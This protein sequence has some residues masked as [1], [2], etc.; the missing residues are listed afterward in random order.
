[1]SYINPN[2][3]SVG[4]NE[5]QTDIG[6]H[7]KQILQ[8]SKSTINNNNS[9]NY[10][11]KPDH[12]SMTN[13]RFTFKN[14][15]M[16]V[17]QSIL[18]AGS[19]DSIPMLVTRCNACLM[20]LKDLIRQAYDLIIP[21]S[22]Y[23]SVILMKTPLSP[24]ITAQILESLKL[25]DHPLLKVAEDRCASCATRFIQLKIDA[26][27]YV[28][29]SVLSVTTG[30]LTRLSPTLMRLNADRMN[31]L[32]NENSYCQS[33]E[34]DNV[35]VDWIRTSQSNVQGVKPTR[36]HHIPVSDNS[37][38]QHIFRLE[39][40]LQNSPQ[41]YKALGFKLLNDHFRTENHTPHYSQGS[42]N[43]VNKLQEPLYQTT[44]SKSAGSTSTFTNPYTQG[45]HKLLNNLT[46]IPS[47]QH[48]IQRTYFPAVSNH[49]NTAIYHQIGIQRS[50][51]TNSNYIRVDTNH[52]LGESSLYAHLGNRETEFQ[53]LNPVCEAIKNKSQLSCP[54]YSRSIR[55]AAENGLISAAK[56][57]QILWES[58]RE[59]TSPL[60]LMQSHSEDHHQ[61]VNNRGETN[62]SIVNIHQRLDNE[63]NETNQDQNIEQDKIIHQLIQSNKG[64]KINQ[65]PS[66]TQISAAASFFTRAGQ[67][68]AVTNNSK[69]KR[70]ILPNDITDINH[71][72]GY[73]TSTLYRYNQQSKCLTGFSEAIHH[74]P[75]P[76]PPTLLKWS[77]NGTNNS[78][79]NIKTSKVKIILQL[80]SDH[81]IDKGSQQKLSYLTVEKRKNQVC[82]NDPNINGN[83]SSTN[84]KCTN[85]HGSKLFAMDGI[86]TEEDSMAE[87]CAF[88]LTDIIQ[89][90]V[91]GSDGCLIS[92]GTR[93]SI[94]SNSMFGDDKQSSGLGII[95]SA[96]SW[97]FRLITEQKER[98]GARFSVRISAVEVCGKEEALRD[99]LSSVS[100]TTDAAG[101]NAP[102]VYLREDPIS[103]T[104][105]ENQSELRA[106]T[107]DKAAFYLDS[108]LSASYQS[109]TT[110]SSSVKS[111]T[112]SSPLDTNS[113]SPTI[114]WKRNSHLFFT[115]HIY[116]Y[117]VERSGISTGVAG[118]RSRLHLIDL[119][120][121]KLPRDVETDNS[122][123]TESQ[124]SENKQTSASLN[125]SMLSLSSMTSV[126]LALINGNRHHPHRNSKLSQMLREAIGSIGCRTCILIQTSPNV[127]YYHENLQLLQFASKIQRSRRH[128]THERTLVGST[129]N[130]SEI[131]SKVDDQNTSSEDSSSCDSFGLRRAGRLRLNMGLRLAM[132]RSNGYKGFSTKYRHYG[133]DNPLSVP[134]S[135]EKDYTSSSEQSCDTVI[136]L[137]RQGL[138]GHQYDQDDNQKAR[139]RLGKPTSGASMDT[140]SEA[141]SGSK[142][143][144]FEGQQSHDS[145][146]GSS[147]GVRR[148][149]GGAESGSLGH[150]GSHTNSGDHCSPH[151]IHSKERKRSAPRTNVYA[152]PRNAVKNA[153]ETLSTQKE[154]WVDGP[155]SD[156]HPS[157]PSH[158]ASQTTTNAVVKPSM[159]DKETQVD[160]LN[161]TSAQVI[162]SPQLSS[163]EEQHPISANCTHTYQ[164]VPGKDHFEQKADELG[165]TEQ[166]KQVQ[167]IQKNVSV[168]P[169]ALERSNITSKSNKMSQMERITDHCPNNGEVQHADTTLS[170]QCSTC[171]MAGSLMNQSNLTVETGD[172]TNVIPIGN[173]IQLVKPQ[174]LESWTVNN[175]NNNNNN[176]ESNTQTNYTIHTSNLNQMTN[177]NPI[178][179]QSS[180]ECHL[181]KSFMN[182]SDTNAPIAKVKPFVKDWIQKHSTLPINTNM[183]EE[184]TKI[185]E[186]HQLQIMKSDENELCTV[187]NANLN[188]ALGE[189]G[190]EGQSIRHHIFHGKTEFMKPEDN[191]CSNISNSKIL[192]N[193]LF[194]NAAL[195]SK[196]PFINSLQTSSN[197]ARIAAWVKSVSVETYNTQES[198][199]NQSGESNVMI[200][201]RESL[202]NICTT[203]KHDLPA[204]HQTCYCRN[205]FE[206]ET[207]F[208]GERHFI[209][210]QMTRSRVCNYENA[211]IQSPQC[212][213]I[214]KLRRG[215]SVPPNSIQEGCHSEVPHSFDEYTKQDSVTTSER[216]T[217]P[218]PISASSGPLYGKEEKLN[219]CRKSDRDIPSSRR[220][221]GSSN[222]HLHKEPQGN[223]DTQNIVSCDNKTQYNSDIFNEKLSHQPTGFWASSKKSH[224][225][226][227]TKP[228]HE[229][230]VGF[231]PTTTNQY[232]N[233]HVKTSPLRKTCFSPETK[234]KSSKLHQENE[235]HL[236]VCTSPK[237][238]K[239]Q[240]THS[241]CSSTDSEHSFNKNDVFLDS[242]TIQKS[243][244]AQN[245]DS[246]GTKSNILQTPVGKKSS[247]ESRT[248]TS[249][250][251]LSF[252]TSPLFGKRK[253]KEVKSS[254]TAVVQEIKHVGHQTVKNFDLRR[255]PL[256]KDSDHSNQNKHS[257]SQVDTSESQT[258]IR[259]IRKDKSSSKHIQSEK[260]HNSSKNTLLS[261]AH[262]GNIPLTFNTP[263]AST[264]ISSMQSSSGHGSECSSSLLTEHN[265]AWNS[266]AE[267]NTSL[268]CRCKRHH[269]HTHQHH[270]HSGTGQRC[271]KCF[272]SSHACRP[273]HHNNRKCETVSETRRSADG[274]RSS[275]SGNS[276]SGYRKVENKETEE[277]D[278][279]C[280]DGKVLLETFETGKLSIG[281][282]SSNV[283][284]SGPRR[285][286]GHAS[287]GYE[288]IVRDSEASSHADSTSGSSAGGIGVVTA[289]VKKNKTIPQKH[290]TTQ[291][292]C[293]HCHRIN[294][295]NV[296]L[297]ERIK[298]PQV[299]QSI[300]TN[301]CCKEEQDKHEPSI[302]SNSYKIQY[303]LQTVQRLHSSKID[304]DVN[305]QELSC[306]GFQKVHLTSPSKQ[307]SQ[308]HSTNSKSSA[309]SKTVTS[310]SLSSSPSTSHRSRSAPPCSE[311]TS[312]ETTSSPISVR[313]VSNKPSENLLSQISTN[314][315]NSVRENSSN[316]SCILP[317]YAEEVQEMERQIRYEKT[318][319]LLAQQD[320]LKMELMTAKD[321]LLIDPSTWSFDLY[322][323][324][325]MDPD[326]PSFLEA[327]EKE[328]EILRKR[329][330][331]CKSHIMLITCFDSQFKSGQLSNV[332]NNTRT[333]QTINI[334][335]TNT[336]LN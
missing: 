225:R 92:F 44:L 283:S 168:K 139:S 171:V 126:V 298:E 107:A 145:P 304:S 116:Q 18:H 122:A 258:R 132:K 325:Q 29:R 41:N 75:P 288:S 166:D 34:A 274:K 237:S 332:I 243:D 219:I 35:K 244:Y 315:K 226:T 128:R 70:K 111:L 103:G 286:G 189:I 67:K 65:Q 175:N 27:S 8:N 117:R 7:E 60:Q 150:S 336:D 154:Q 187:I 213:K 26:L 31:L 174:S 262:A 295:T 25:P 253:E 56:Q 84:L 131:N 230:T 21:G 149:S 89:S 319:D 156:F 327:L 215:R 210:H 186:H 227:N 261:N 152:W 74:H 328:T 297:D 98:T 113:S 157:N 291:E 134:A 238:S 94:K 229:E 184:F 33:S 287:S 133:L 112:A 17:L 100:N 52:K 192:G 137:G 190:N 73:N 28:R 183:H 4:L 77:R 308:Q 61:S 260:Q 127:N 235:S 303:N 85:S 324:E 326:D 155:K 141:S 182:H 188:M 223:S 181:T 97:L 263:I 265:S 124:N 290:C 95:P 212:T 242:C 11:N 165:K 185:N 9:N 46:F 119:G 201:P 76:M 59:K 273:D 53:H 129:S 208:S 251:R 121:T 104:Q 221:D 241:I 293:E 62:P 42:N 161:Q 48:I 40:S 55:W 248:K 268:R 16:S 109:V 123:D 216:T 37:R 197:F 90:V 245:D 333:N 81:E 69:R 50:L 278:S 220:P 86:F 299:I 239:C 167:N 321:R 5:L 259:C 179:K 246:I 120:N 87:L 191:S 170:S 102:G 169:V 144:Q 314:V 240:R 96:I 64:S 300:N 250:G 302:Q 277:H 318:Y 147:V 270:H 93:D 294:Q 118:G 142:V 178:M 79:L 110:D 14:T 276:I 204:N 234:K 209:P 136:Y 228:Y 45:D 311:D 57:Q 206:N 19:M 47:G 323:A 236:L 205:N 224:F 316:V 30:K 177:V 58:S 39:S 71:L 305:N 247:K 10:L 63:I 66:V 83:E 72:S 101:A 310:Q 231:S 108:A 20:C 148:G 275:E 233:T 279:Q 1:M 38:P 269:H 217:A 193:A 54:D 194:G 80:R 135:S 264:K 68:L 282:P 203:A 284:G 159:I 335:Y 78:A 309:T 196:Q 160:E 195:Q 105:L 330:D 2:Y 202:T 255:K 301:S 32:P 51:Q 173:N 88:A 257:S 232:S 249:K 140:G 334:T 130:N 313:Y 125:D 146:V 200:K 6:F 143:K 115:L 15:T 280:N 254:E 12:I 222:P 256:T 198:G 82:L 207:M 199:P 211:I 138:L 307:P 91:N 317:M 266:K 180:N 23:Y 43:E 3:Q 320:M 13:K 281:I 163:Q 272:Q 292:Y 252:L 172:L 151:A 114:L 49:P 289:D 285:G 312:E 106:P 271:H 306:Q 176:H 322:V 267:P 158:Q 214:G 164:K 296:P 22:P 36:L 329:V 162:I 218:L 99:L 331:A 24:A 153:I